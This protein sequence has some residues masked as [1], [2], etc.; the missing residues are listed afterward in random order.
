M[1][2]MTQVGIRKIVQFTTSYVSKFC[3]LVSFSM[4]Q[5]LMAANFDAS[6]FRY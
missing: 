6:A 2:L 3:L 5:N 4:R 1:P